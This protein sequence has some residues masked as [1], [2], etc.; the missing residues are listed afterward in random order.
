M[1]ATRV[2]CAHA[3]C[4]VGGE[5]S[6]RLSAFMDIA[7][8]T[9]LSAAA[10]RSPETQRWDVLF[11]SGPVRMCGVEAY[12][13]L[14][15]EMLELRSICLERTNIVEERKQ[16]TIGKNNNQKDVRVEVFVGEGLRGTH[17]GTSRN[18]AAYPPP[19]TSGFPGRE[20]EQESAGER[21]A[22]WRQELEGWGTSLWLLP[23][24]F[25]AGPELKDRN[26]LFALI[27]CFGLLSHDVLSLLL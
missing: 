24:G 15:L 10:S 5:S 17:D 27:V 4:L 16:L 8:L 26:S 25:T 2:G 6:A 12:L 23:R 1:Y 14:E 7:R 19:P 13:G 9:R 11:E 21:R 22:A 3:A 18:S 20:R